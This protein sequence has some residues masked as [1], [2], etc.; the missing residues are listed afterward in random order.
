[1]ADN[2]DV[3]LE[4]L[5]DAIRSLYSRPSLTQSEINNLMTSLA[6]KF[7]NSTESNAQKFIGIIVNETRK[8]LE[9]KQGEMRQQLTGFENL[10]KQM[11]QGLSNPKMSMEVTKILNEV[12]DMYAKLGSQE[13]ALQKINQTLIT[14]KSANPINEI[15]KLSNEFNVFSR[16][17]ENITHT[18]N[19]NFTDFLNQIKSYNSKEELTDIQLELDTINGNV[20]S[21]IS[22]LSII[23]HKYR[24]LTGLVD[25]FHSKEAVFDQSLEGIKN[26]A[27]KFDNIKEDISKNATK[28]DLTAFK[29]HLDFVNKNVDNIGESINQSFSQNDQKFTN[30]INLIETKLT[31]NASIEDLNKLK[32]EIKTLI[33]K[34]SIQQAAGKDEFIIKFQESLKNLKAQSDADLKNQI[35]DHANGVNEGINYISSQMTK[36]QESLGASFL[37]KTQRMNEGV[38]NLKNKL[39]LIEQ[40]I[41]KLPKENILQEVKT[42]EES[43]KTLTKDSLSSIVE[44]VSSEFSSLDK[45]L[46][47]KNIENNRKVEFAINNLRDDIKSFNE[48]FS[49]LKNEISS[50]NQG[51]IDSIKEPLEKA[52]KELRETTI[53][54]QL[55]IIN[56][57]IKN[58]TFSI[59]D[60]FE[61]IK[62]N[63]EHAASGTNVEILS[64]LNNTIP[65]ISEKLE[66]LRGQLTQENAQNTEELKI[67]FQEAS[68]AIKTYINE[69]K[70]SYDSPLTELKVDL[71]ALSNYLIESVENININ[72]SKE[73]EE[74]K[75]TIKDY[76]ENDEKINLENS[77]IEQALNAAKKDLIEGI[78]GSTKNAKANFIILE[79]KINKILENQNSNSQQTVIELINKVLEKQDFKN[80]DTIIELINKILE[81]Q[82]SNSQQTVIELI[83]KVLEN[84]NTSNN[85]VIIELINK[86]IE[87]QNSDIQEEAIELLNKILKNQAENQNSNKE[88]MLLEVINNIYDKIQHTN[89]QQIHN[90]K[91]LLEEIQNNSSEITQKLD[92][93]IKKQP[94]TDIIDKIDLINEKLELINADKEKDLKDS[95]KL[96]EEQL[97][98]TTKE[99]TEQFSF[100]NEESTQENNLNIDEYLSKIDEYLTNVEYL[101][102][103]LS[104][105]LK[106]CIE[107]QVND[108]HEKFEKVLS[109]KNE[110]TKIETYNLIQKVSNVEN[111][112]DKITRNVSK[113]INS[114]D[115]TSYAYSL[116]DVESDIAKLRLTIEKNLKGENYREFINRLIELKNINIEN[117]KLNHAIEGQMGYLNNW[118]KSTAQKLEIL[119]QQVE[120]AEKMSMEEIK[121]RLIRSEKSPDSGKIEEATRRQISY[122]EDLDEKLNVL[123]QRQQDGFDP[124]SFIDVTYENMK[125]TK[126]LASRMDEM[127]IKIDKIQGYMEKIVAYIEE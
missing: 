96:L 125:Q 47:N 83:N 105:D 95:I 44:L 123:L 79:E 93:Y 99:L 119:S 29:E 26:I 60:S 69:I 87:N 12:T 40:N 61:K 84:Q 126:E 116:Q 53:D 78:L 15:V 52:L 17:F 31:Q 23:E 109:A 34:L 18:L 76:F 1:M 72:I 11:T 35:F 16:G 43:L 27:D 62:Q 14:N 94:H 58:T 101:K 19:K 97:E 25:A 86:I 46:E 4:Q 2:V 118:L 56:Q 3:K 108:L 63:F 49:S 73:F 88:E 106:E 59:N 48:K 38:N 104:E 117:N 33:D 111:D 107:I 120:N 64:K 66:L 8:A 50:L 74:Y 80:E 5:T 32:G 92:D 57:N 98:N 68:E 65:L 54:E 42:I 71:Q 28:E 67:H 9:E 115:D 85:D 75:N 82:N 13:I 21:I 7:E 55:N 24:D 100:K 110:E 30:A 70:D 112:I 6:Q 127:E 91:E 36:L 22:A 103:N 81:N 113:I 41:Q 77:N 122:L 20:N 114:N 10:I 45:S 37:D 121:T 51:S 39:D 102:N 90:A 124:T 89:Q